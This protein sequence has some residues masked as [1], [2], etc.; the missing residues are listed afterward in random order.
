MSSTVANWLYWCVCVLC[1][2]LPRSILQLQSKSTFCCSCLHV[3]W[4]RGGLTGSRIAGR[5]GR[6]HEGEQ[7]PWLGARELS[8]VCI[9]SAGLGVICTHRQMQSHTGCD[10]KSHGPRRVNI[11]NVSFLSHNQIYY[12][13][14]N[15]YSQKHCN[16]HWQLFWKWK[17]KWS[18]ILAFK[19]FRVVEIT[20]WP[21]LYDKLA[22]VFGLVKWSWINELLRV[23]GV[24]WMNL[25]FGQRFVNFVHCQRIVRGFLELL[26]RSNERTK[27]PIWA[28]TE[29]GDRYSKPSVS[30]GSFWLFWILRSLTRGLHQCGKYS[31]L[32]SNCAMKMGDCDIV[33]TCAV[34]TVTMMARRD[35]DGR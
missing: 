27:H 10:I 31:N 16:S 4:L 23:W 9:N 33:T 34:R 3:Y 12:I 20:S 19:V 28:I 17:S 29:I 5:C 35:R 7:C 15:M 32:C 8:W 22:S 11:V 14:F 18:S 6:V 30:E 26:N 25:A 24:S 2:F 21:G 1:M 13:D